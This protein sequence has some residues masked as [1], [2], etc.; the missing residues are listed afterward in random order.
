MTTIRM[1]AVRLGPIRFRGGFDGRHFPMSGYI[2]AA[3]LLMLLAL[4]G[5]QLMQLYVIFVCQD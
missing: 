3:L 4:A 5:Y 2:V 1:C